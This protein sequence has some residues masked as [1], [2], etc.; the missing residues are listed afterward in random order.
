V[1]SV[2]EAEGPPVPGEMRVSDQER[3]GAVE[4]LSEHAVAG[5]LT[6]DELEQRVSVALTA[7]TRGQLQ[8][9]TRDLPGKGEGAAGRRKAFAGWSLSWAV[10]THRRLSRPLPVR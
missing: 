5:R 4:Q 3:D 1:Q 8:A 6:L 2:D 10:R 7:R 9:L